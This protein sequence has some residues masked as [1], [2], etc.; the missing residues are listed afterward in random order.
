MAIA[1]RSSWNQFKHFS[2]FVSSFWAIVSILTALF[3]LWSDYI[4][5]FPLPNDFLRIASL[6]AVVLGCGAFIAEY[7][8]RERIGREAS[9]KRKIKNPRYNPDLAFFFSLILIVGLVFTIKLTIYERHSAV[10]NHY[11][12]TGI[13]DPITRPDFLPKKDSKVS[14]EGWE[15]EEYLNSQPEQD[16]NTKILELYGRTW[17]A[18]AWLILFFTYVFSFALLTS[19]FAQLAVREY[20]RKILPES[21]VGPNLDRQTN[22]G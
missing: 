19:G 12:I 20:M 3:P 18:G 7:V 22:G 21:T 17:V 16:L 4:R 5:I 6:T 2:T 15:I 8:E 9:A 13:V 11:Y 14:V 10:G 1:E